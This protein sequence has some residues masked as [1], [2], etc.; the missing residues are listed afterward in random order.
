MK[1]R[2]LVTMVCLSTAALVGGCNSP[3]GMGYSADRFVYRSDEWQPWTVS[4]IDTRTGE[5]VWSVDVPVGKQLVMG[6]RKGV[7]PNEFKPDI[8]YWGITENGRAISR[9]SNQLPVPGA[10]SRRLEPV[11]RPTPELP[12]TPLPGSPYM[13]SMNAD[14]SEA[15]A[16]G[17]M[18]PGTADLFAPAKQRSPVA[19]P[20]PKPA[21]APSE[22]AHEA[23]TSPP[24]SETAPPAAPEPVSPP[25]ATPEDPPVDL[26]QGTRGPR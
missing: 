9:Q 17:K 10:M 2:L 12:G 18:E 20:A 13:A 1:T 16:K 23:P 7:G 11:L 4:L 15:A 19:S 6:F 5:S 21:A 22:P 14:K 8:M 3:G 24:P 25:P 26:P